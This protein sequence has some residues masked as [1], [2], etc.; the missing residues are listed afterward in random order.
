MGDRVIMKYH[1]QWKPVYVSKIFSPLSG[2]EPGTAR[3]AD[4]RLTTELPGLPQINGF[5][6]SQS[7]K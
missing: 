3:S 6:V 2:I 7:G 4:Q 5:V 1:V